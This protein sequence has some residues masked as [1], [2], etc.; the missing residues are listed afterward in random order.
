[1]KAIA[2][3]G[4]SDSGKTAVCTVLIEGLRRR[5]YT[6]GSVKEIHCKDFAIDVP[7]TDTARHREAGSQLVTAR[8]CLET[9]ILFQSKLPIA[10][11]LSHYQQDYVILEGVT[12]CNVPRIIT[13]H[14]L[15][16][17]KERMDCRAIAVSGVIAKS[18]DS[19]ILGL[20]VFNAYKDSEALLDFVVERAFSP[21]PSFS[22]DCC[23]RCGYS[24][25]ELAGRIA[26]REA[27]REDCLLWSQETELTVD[28]V[29]I[30][31][32]PFV[33]TILKNAVLAIA[34][35]LE[36][37]KEKSTVEVRFNL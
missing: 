23:G 8:G 2:V 9:D 11:I 3:N 22:K 19:N 4:T 37:F 33:Q 17:V 36:G 16:E 29:P 34:G 35:E 12:D 20:P 26:Q 30:A 10:E 14:N 7:G 15:A 18:S 25:G 21:L 24:C 1:M 13:A 31:M 32:V 6:V 27:E 5:G 28:G